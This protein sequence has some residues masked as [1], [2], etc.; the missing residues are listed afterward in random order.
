MLL[1]RDRCLLLLVDF[2]E[3]LLPALA[4]GESAL[5]NA[6][7]L[8][9]AARRLGLPARATEQYP[10]G[11]GVTD[12]R[13]RGEL[14][15]G[16]ILEKTHFNAAREGSVADAVAATRRRTLVL[17]GAEAHVC[18]LQTALGFQSQGYAVAVVADATA[19]RTAENAQLG[20]GR[21][22]RAGV[23]IVSTEM[24]LFEWIGQAATPEFRDLLPLIK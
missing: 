12:A 2:Q 7:R 24:A 21:M 18:V 13:L 17:A 16:E 5:G 3:R 1:D 6:E 22:R 20:L 10:K 14:D 11:L 4:G 19:S 15:P 23:E 9:T 8:L